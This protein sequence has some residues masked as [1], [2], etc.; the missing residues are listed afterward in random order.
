VLS[1]Y[2]IQTIILPNLKLYQAIWLYKLFYIQ[3]K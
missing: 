1:N 3:E 2:Q